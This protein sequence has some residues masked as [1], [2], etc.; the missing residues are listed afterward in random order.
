MSDKGAWE[1]GTFAMDTRF[2]RVGKVMGHIGPYVQLRP[3]RG[4]REW[5]ADPGDLRRLEPRERLNARL[6]EVNAQS[7]NRLG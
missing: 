4:G 2:D 5:D 7:R 3:P 6:A 1:I